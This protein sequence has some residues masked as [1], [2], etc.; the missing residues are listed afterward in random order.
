M[1]KIPNP[2]AE[3]ALLVAELEIAFADLDRLLAL[4]SIVAA[5]L[6]GEQPRVDR[7]LLPGGM[8]PSGAGV[9]LAAR[10]LLE[11]VQKHLAGAEFHLGQA[12]RIKNAEEY[13]A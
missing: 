12:D 10:V 1:N 4:A 3:G 9:R 5:H 7:R 11:N 6:N 2:E 8:V 13:G